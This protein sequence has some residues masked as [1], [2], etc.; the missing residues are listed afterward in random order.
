MKKKRKKRKYYYEGNYGPRYIKERLD[1]LD[2][3]RDPCPLCGKD[4]LVILR[5]V[6]QYEYYCA[7]RKCDVVFHDTGKQMVRVE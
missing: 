2:P 4:D 7:C 6:T 1:G 5:K 3:L